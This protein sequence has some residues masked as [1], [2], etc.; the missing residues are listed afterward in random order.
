MQL[1]DFLQK[2]QRAGSGLLFLCY[3]AFMKRFLSV[4][5]L[6]I[7]CS[8]YALSPGNRAAMAKHMEAFCMSVASSYIA[9]SQVDL[10]GVAIEADGSFIPDRIAFDNADLGAFRNVLLSKQG[11]LRF[12]PLSVSRP[13]AE[14]AISLID[15]Y[16]IRLGDFIVDG[17]AVITKVRDISMTSLLSGKT[18]SID[19]EIEFDGVI[20]DR[21][22]V[23][24]ATLKGK[25]RVKGLND[26]KLLTEFDYLII[27][28]AS[29]SI[30]AIES[31]LA[32]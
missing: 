31:E 27:D 12:L 6:F 14:G 8:L 18:E 32:F 9:L 25:V 22:L 30:P 24:D 4:L 2:S 26:R 10:P 16:G 11:A 19:I 17:E 1:I 29:Y 3:D 13:F 15:E 5:F 7:S 23:V 21:I 28:G 20:C